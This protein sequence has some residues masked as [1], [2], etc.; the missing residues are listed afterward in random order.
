MEIKERIKLLRQKTGLSQSKFA[1]RFEIP[2]RTLQQWE[3]GQSAPPEYVVRMMSYI[4]LLEQQGVLKG[5]RK[6]LP[7]DE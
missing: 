2:V 3:Q 5:E 4:L 1:A 7:P 6:L